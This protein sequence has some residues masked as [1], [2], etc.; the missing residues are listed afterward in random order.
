VPV[1]AGNTTT[2]AQVAPMRPLVQ[3]SVMDLNGE[4]QVKPVS[5]HMGS[6]GGVL[7]G[8]GY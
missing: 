4:G 3:L 7:V 2:R 8:G 6:C 5:S 1:P